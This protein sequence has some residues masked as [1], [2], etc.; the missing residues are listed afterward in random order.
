M[1]ALV[2]A[3]TTVWRNFAHAGQPRLVPAAYP[4]VASPQQ[5]LDEIAA[6]HRS[7]APKPEG[8]RDSK[9]PSAQ[10]RPRVSPSLPPAVSSS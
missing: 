8:R 7:R 3:D 2:V 6:G 10:G 1:T 5:V 9:R 4:G